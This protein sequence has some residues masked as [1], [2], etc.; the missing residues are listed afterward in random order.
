MGFLTFLWTLSF[1]KISVAS[2]RC[3]FSKILP[4]S[5]IRFEQLCHSTLHIL[6]AVPSQERQ[7]QDQCHP[8]SIDEEKEGQERVYGSFGDNVGV[9]AVAK[10][11]RVDVV[12]ASKL[13]CG[14]GEA[15]FESHAAQLSPCWLYWR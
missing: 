5:V 2:R 7:V 13:A 15:C 6:L 3:W 12:T 4:W 14:R 1:L 11:D 10:I 8:V 9:E